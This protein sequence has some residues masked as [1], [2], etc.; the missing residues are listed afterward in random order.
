MRKLL[1][2]LAED[3]TTIV[4]PGEPVHWRD[5]KYAGWAHAKILFGYDPNAG[6]LFVD[7][8]Y[9]QRS[10]RPN[11]LEFHGLFWQDDEDFRRQWRWLL[12]TFIEVG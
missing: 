5:G 12:G 11:S 6:L 9:R 4:L 2:N 10:D 3:R 7:P 1:R 8:A